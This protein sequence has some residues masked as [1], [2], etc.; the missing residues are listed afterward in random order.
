M[1]VK[2]WN[3]KTIRW[4]EDGYGCL[5]DMAKATGKKVNDWLRLKS[6]NEFLRAFSE[7]TG[8]TV[9]SLVLIN[10]SEGSNSDRGTWADRRICIEF[11]RWCNPKF[12]VQVILWIDE[13]MTKGYVDIRN[14]SAT[15]IILAQA[16]SLFDLERKQ[17]QNDQ[18]IIRLQIEHMDAQLALNEVIERNTQIETQLGEV[19]DRS[20]AIDAE[21][22]RIT[23]PDGDYFSILGYAN[24]R[25]LRPVSRTEAAVLGREASRI[26]RERG[27]P[28][29]KIKD[30]RFGKVGSYPETVLDELFAENDDN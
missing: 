2:S 28:V 9:G 24:Y 16:Q 13:I 14:L 18:E 15:E 3:E 1:L 23:S 10:E 4:R 22:Q 29:Q 5:T 30:V 6:T 8:I 12:A 19:I 25:N 27:V 26:C 21:L 20:N 17:K 11:A 7:S